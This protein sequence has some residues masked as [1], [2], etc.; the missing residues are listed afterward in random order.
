[1]AKRDFAKEAHNKGQKDS[2]TSRTSK[3][4][5]ITGNNYNPPSGR[6]KEYRKGWDNNKNQK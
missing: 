3:G 1:M 5:S 2:A 4:Y 6:G